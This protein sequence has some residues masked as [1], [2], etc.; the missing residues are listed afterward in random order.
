[1]AAMIVR[2]YAASDFDALVKLWDATGISA[3]YNDFS[4]EVPRMEATEN[5][6]LYVGC[7]DERLIASIMVGHEGYRG[8]VYKLTVEPRYRSKGYGRD[9]MLQAERWLVARGVPKCNLMIRDTNPK[10]REFYERLGY[11]AAGFVVM[12]R[13][14]RLEE[15]DMEPA[16]LDVV[17]TYLEM[18]ERPTRPTVPCPAGQHAVMRLERVSL[19]FYRY[20]YN[21]V[22]EPWL[23]TDRRRLSDAELDAEINAD[24]VEIY[25]LYAGGEPAGYVELDRRAKPG[26]HIAYFGLAPSF[27]GRGLGRYL[28]N[29]AVDLA[30]SYGPERLTVSTWSFD[31]PRALANYQ[32]AGFRPYKQARGR[33]LDPRLEG[34]IPAHVQPR[35]TAPLSAGAT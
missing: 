7:V 4:T 21:L 8:W 24:G 19:A 28:L 33:I 23:W 16:E 1:M 31:H 15:I 12:E 3:P 32:K 13:W 29:W 20:L 5:C 18:T 6:Q 27:I 10:V 35:L 26:I 34:L 11:G 30:W 22:G 9:L 25:V 14:L 2:P 17:T